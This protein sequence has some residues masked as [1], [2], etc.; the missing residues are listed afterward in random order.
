M[1]QPVLE[2]QPQGLRR[3]GV[4]GHVGEV[5]EQVAVVLA[6]GIEGDLLVRLQPRDLA[7]QLLD[8][9]GQ[10]GVA[11]PGS[12]EL[13]PECVETVEDGREQLARRVER[14]PPARGAFGHRC[15]L[16]AAAPRRPSEPTRATTSVNA[17]A[18]RRQANSSRTYRRPAAP[19]PFGDVRAPSDHLERGGELVGVRVADATAGAL[20]VP[21]EDPAAPLHQRRAL[22]Q[23]ALHEREREALH[24]GRLHHHLGAGHERSLGGLVDEAGGAHPVRARQVSPGSD[25]DQLEVRVDAPAVQLGEADGVVAALGRVDATDD[26]AVSAA[27]SADRADGAVDLVG[28]RAGR[29]ARPG[30]EPR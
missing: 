27:A 22:E 25:D 2:P 9:R 29:R 3:G 11:L 7:R 17:S 13:G 21:G 14:E 26:D 20:R 16:A 18:T 6:D 10:L 4:V 24:V 15:M 28:P 19:S 8:L 30:T 5:A 1:Q 23:P 12:D